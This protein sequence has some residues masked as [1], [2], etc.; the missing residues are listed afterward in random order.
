MKANIKII[1]CF[2]VLCSCTIREDFDLQGHRGYRGY[3]PENSIIGFTKAL[4]IGVNT[5]ELD[6]VISRDKKVV[7]SHEPWMSENICV[8][9]IGNEL[10]D[11]KTTYNIYS[12]DYEYIKKFDCGI[13]GNNRFIE[14][15]KISSFKPTLDSV[16]NFI[17]SYAHNNNI[18][19]PKYN[20]EIKSSLDSDF[21]FHPSVKDFSDLVYN[22]IDSLNISERV[23]IQ[24][25]DFRILKYFHENY[26][27]I[28][29]SVL[30]SENYD[31]KKNLIDLGF[32]PH[33]YSPNF[34]N[35]VY[36]DIIFLRKKNIKI[37]PW[38]V[39]SFSDIA[40]IL[41]MGTNGIITDYPERVLDLRK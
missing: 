14:Q 15:K 35:L 1:I 16:V 41:E 26:P 9:S 39:N 20:I 23:I 12:M 29:L 34:K 10:K 3:Y 7:V 37:I 31:P 40:E 11:P 22:I 32:E 36:E 38:T 13:K 25:F 17:E 8:D 6:V 30:V 21:I 5:L 27:E 33:I 4:E 19:P 2:F 24:S 18:Q 28:V